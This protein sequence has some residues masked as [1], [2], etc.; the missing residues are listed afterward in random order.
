MK[1]YLI[2]GIVFFALGI[3]YGGM[4]I[5]Y[6]LGVKHGVERTELCMDNWGK[7]KHDGWEFYC[8]H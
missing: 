5:A 1:K 2:I 8:L 6:N 4:R 3:M 7:M